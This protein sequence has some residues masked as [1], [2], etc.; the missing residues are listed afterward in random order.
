MWQR[1]QRNA[2]RAK[3]RALDR[4]GGRIFLQYLEE[5]KQKTFRGRL[6]Q[7]YNDTQPELEKLQLQLTNEK[8]LATD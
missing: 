2:E 7:E 5:E 6:D 3:K 4:K 1:K 8:V